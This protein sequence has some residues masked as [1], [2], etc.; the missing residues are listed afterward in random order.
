[1]IAR[2]IGTGSARWLVNGRWQR[3]TELAKT[4]SIKRSVTAI[5]AD[6]AQVLVGLR[7]SG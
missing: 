7:S 2:E 3:L 6:N 4:V 5:F 1:M